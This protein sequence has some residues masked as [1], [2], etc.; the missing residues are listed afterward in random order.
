M[1]FSRSS[2]RAMQYEATYDYEM[3]SYH[4]RETALLD[5]KLQCNSTCSRAKTPFASF[6]HGEYRYS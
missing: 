4:V 3:C 1:I 5:R 2:S 6:D